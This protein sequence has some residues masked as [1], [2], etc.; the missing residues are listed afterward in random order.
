MSGQ[1]I[2]PCFKCGGKVTILPI[3]GGR[4]SND[5]TAYAASCKCGMEERE[6]SRDGT[7]R[8]AVRQYNAYAKKASQ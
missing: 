7:M 8:D 3:Y 4:G 1:I 2:A 5:L 6:L